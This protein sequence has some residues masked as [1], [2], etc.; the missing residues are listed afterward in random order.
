MN[1]ELNPL[2]AKALLKTLKALPS[3]TRAVRAQTQRLEEAIEQA[4]RATEGERKRRFE[5]FIHGG[6]DWD[7]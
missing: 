3:P 7:K 2:T 1:V 5:N 6:P 4:R